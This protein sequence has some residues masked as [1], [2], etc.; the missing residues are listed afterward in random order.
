ME[1]ERERAG[2]EEGGLVR[3]LALLLARASAWERAER[4][5]AAEAMGAGDW[6]ERFLKMEGEGDMVRAMGDGKGELGAM[7]GEDGH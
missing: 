7:L 4:Y 5:D 1:E 6:E 3:G 2:V